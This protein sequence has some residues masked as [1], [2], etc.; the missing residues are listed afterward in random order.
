MEKKVAEDSD[1][2]FDQKQLKFSYDPADTNYELDVIQQKMLEFYVRADPKFRRAFSTNFTSEFFQ[3]IRDKTRL[4]EP[5][6]LTVM[7]QVRSAKS[8]SMISVCAYH[9]AC[10]NKPFKIDYVCANAYEFVD[11]LQ[12]MPQDKLT[13]RIFLIDEEKQSVYGYG[14]TAKKMKLA[15][16]QNI[17]AI[18]NIS[19]ISINPTSWANAE[20]FYGLR[21]FGR[22]FKTK[23]ARL[24]MYNLQSG[25][26]GSS[27][28]MGMLYIPIFTAFLP[29]TFAERLE[30]QYL[31]KKNKWVQA[32]QRG[33]GDVL[34]EMKKKLAKQFIHDKKFQLLRKKNEKLTYI[35]T[36][37][38]SEWTTKE[39]E[40]ILSLVGIMAQGIDF[41]DGK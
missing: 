27:T 41:D 9:Q 37:L 35:T 3:F 39:C 15:D 14:S 20:A 4:N 7:G 22:C 6:H 30:K 10:Y 23:T 26:K 19:S 38:G 18:N 29:K 36:V 28:P 25:D 12:D 13:N 5:L 11:K 33:E 21:T 34:A 24:M 40:A 16:V 17:I 2:Y 31:E 1:D 8:Y 32:E